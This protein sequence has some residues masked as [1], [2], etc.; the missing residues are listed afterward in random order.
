MIYQNNVDNE[1]LF[2]YFELKNVPHKFYFDNAQ[3]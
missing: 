2:F 3:I 1:V